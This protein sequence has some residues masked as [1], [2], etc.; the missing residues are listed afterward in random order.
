MRCK[1]FGMAPQ[2]SSATSSLAQAM[3]LRYTVGMKITN[4]LPDPGD[5]LH[6]A[7]CKCGAKFEFQCSEAETIRQPAFLLKVNCPECQ[8]EVVVDPERGTDNVRRAKM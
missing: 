2:T 7:R 8:R 3:A 6:R 4:P 5:R 1:F